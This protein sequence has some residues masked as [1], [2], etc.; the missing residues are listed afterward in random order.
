M[1]T[2][3]PKNKLTRLASIISLSVALILVCIKIWAWM[4]TGS[5]ALLTSAA[6][7]LVDVLASMVTLVGVYYAQQPADCCHRFGH[8]K[9]EAIAAFLQALFLGA[10]GGMLGIES[11]NRLMTPEILNAQWIS[12]IVIVASTIC[13]SLLVA[14]QTQVVKYTQSTAISADRNHYITD[15][16]VNITILFALILSHHFGWIRADAGGALAISCYMIWHA[17]CMIQSAMLQLLDCELGS[18]DRGRITA[19][20]LSC[21]GVDGVHDLRTRN[22]GDRVFVEL[23]V[24]VDGQ[25][26]VDAGHDICDNAE[27]AVKALFTAVEVSVHLEPSGIMDKRLDDLIK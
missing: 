13:A 15:I 20:A 9:A 23:H 12:I 21:P 8:G 5:I 6:D 10:T 17:C 18:T 3:I 7:G 16:A 4:E 19:A 14:M 26:T 22:G 11:V 27:A 2:K 25:L 24:E 1:F